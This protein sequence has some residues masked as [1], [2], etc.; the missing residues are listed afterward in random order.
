MK[1]AQACNNSQKIQYKNVTVSDRNFHAQ[2]SKLFKA[3]KEFKPL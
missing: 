3:L 1:T 2:K